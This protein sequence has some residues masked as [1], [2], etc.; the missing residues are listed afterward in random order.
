M[1]LITIIMPAYNCEKTVSRSV[2]S[3][4]KQTYKKFE[5]IIVMMVQQIERRVFV[6]HLMIEE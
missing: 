1:E 6:N 4:L 5:V 2:E 3:I